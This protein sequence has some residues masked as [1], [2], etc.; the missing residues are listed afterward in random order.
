MNDQDKLMRK[1]LQETKSIA[2]VGI[3][4]DENKSSFEVA[5]YLRESGYR[6]FPVN[7]KLTEWLGEKAYP[8]LLA[9]PEKVDAINIFRPSD[10]VMPF[11]DQAIQIG[12]KCVWLPLGIINEAAAKK[13]RAAGLD[14][15]MNACMMIEYGRLI[16]KQT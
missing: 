7:P 13:A 5:Y 15:V 12:A 9:I 11:V 6:I 8:D 3:S 2:I 1:I 16:G 10:Q 4:A 14:V